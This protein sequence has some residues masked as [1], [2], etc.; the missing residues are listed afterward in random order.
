MRSSTHLLRKE[1][2][3]LIR[4]FELSKAEFWV[5][6]L[7][8]ILQRLEDPME[9]EKARIDLDNCF[10][11][12]GSLNDLVLSVTNQNLPEGWSEEAAND[13][14]NRLLNRVFKENRLVGKSRFDRFKWK[15]LEIKHRNDLPPRI[16][17]SFSRDVM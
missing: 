16:L 4:F 15:L 12:M 3:R 9:R 10:G 7:G 1:L 6:F 13:H 8:G 2:V 11:G 17:N 14:L 5:K